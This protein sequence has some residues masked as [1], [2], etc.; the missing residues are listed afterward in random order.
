M[1][2]QKYCK[3]SCK[4]TE[5][6]ISKTF[7]PSHSGM[8][9]GKVVFRYQFATPKA[10]KNH[11]SKIPFKE[12]KQEYWVVSIPTLIGNLGGV[13]GLFSG[14]SFLTCFESLMIVVME[15]IWRRIKPEATDKVKS[16]CQNTIQNPPPV[17]S[18]KLH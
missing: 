8:P 16:E 2:Q 7:Q 14:F 13:L 17:H 3:K 5:Y 9:L 6:T 18:T 12:V 11:M 4:I 1:D 10:T 15:N